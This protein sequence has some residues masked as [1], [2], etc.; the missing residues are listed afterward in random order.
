MSL[1]YT[2]KPNTPEGEEATIVKTGHVHEFKLSEVNSNLIQIEKTIKETTAQMQLSGA[3]MTNI[4][5]HHPFVKDFSDKELYTISLYYASKKLKDTCEDKLKT[6]VEYAE[7]EKEALIE[8][9]KQTG[10]KLEET[11]APAPVEEASAV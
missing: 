1:T 10:L 4:E 9:E 2:V 7:S 3:E 5:S 6:F 8:I 11:P